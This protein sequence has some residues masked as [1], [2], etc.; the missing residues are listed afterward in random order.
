MTGTPRIELANGASENG[1]ALMLSELIRQNLDDRPEKRRDFHRLRGRIAIVVEDAR[2][3]VTL[4]FDASGLVVHDGIAGLPDLT[5]R[6]DSEMVTEMSLVEILPVLGVP[7]PRREHAKSVMRAS[8][9]GRVRMYGALVNLP[10]VLRLTRLM[11]V[12]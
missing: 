11:S 4:E 10:T 3:A 7:D 8:Q 2:V 6:T 1:F 9:N 5:I 12:A